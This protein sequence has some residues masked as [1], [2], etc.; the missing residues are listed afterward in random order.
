M[1]GV[2]G[3]RTALDVPLRPALGLLFFDTVILTAV[4]LSVER[5]IASLERSFAAAQD[6]SSSVSRH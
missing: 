3:A 2:R 4:M 5:S 1:A 6:D